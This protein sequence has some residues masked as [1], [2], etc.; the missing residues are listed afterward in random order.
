MVTLTVTNTAPGATAT[1]AVVFSQTLASASTDPTTGT[2]CAGSSP[3]Q[4]YEPAGGGTVWAWDAVSSGLITG[5][6]CSLGS[7]AITKSVS[8]ASTTVPVFTFSFGFVG[9][10][11]SSCLSSCSTYTTYTISFTAHNP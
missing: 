10:Q 2:A 8:T 5:G 1:Y 3:N 9:M 4:L 7:G 6:A 11:A